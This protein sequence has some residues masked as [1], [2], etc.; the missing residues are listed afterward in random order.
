MKIGIID[1]K[2]GNIASLQNS[3][4]KIGVTPSL[5][6]DPEALISCDKV[7]LPGVGA[8]HDAAEHL[9]ENGMDE[10][11]LSYAKSGKDLFGICLGLQ[12]LFQNSEE[13]RGAEGLGLI[14][15][16][17]VHFSSNT[18]KEQL[19]IPHMGWNKMFVSKEDAL[20][21]GIENP[22][23]YFVHSYHVECDDKYV[24]GRTDYGETFVSAVR[25]EN[26]IGLQPHPEKSHDHGLKIL[27]NFS[28]L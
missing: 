22:Y 12:L 1:Y 2:M 19:K 20:F 16:K 9:S 13:S 23:L 10:A 15:G 11:I 26:V 8:F 18:P 5:I 25:H 6:S 4:E 3:F 14:P 27:K 21:N 7:I 24:L 17:V 28:D